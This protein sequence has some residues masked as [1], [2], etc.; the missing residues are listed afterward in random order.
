[1]LSYLYMLIREKVSL[2]H[3]TTFRMGPSTSY[4]IEIKTTSDLKEACSF[5]KNKN[6]PILVIGGG[7]NV[8]FKDEKELDAVVLNIKIKGL[9]ILEDTS[10]YSLIE[11]GAGE[12][13]DEVVDFSVRQGLTGIECLSYIPGTAG[14]TPVQNVGA[15]GQEISDTLVHLTAYEVSSGNMRTFTKEE[16]GFGYRNSVFKQESK[17]KYV[18]TSIV[19]KLSK[20]KPS[21][22]SYPGVESYF[23]KH[24]IN[25]P[26]LE[27]I[28]Q[29]II[30]IRKNKLPDPKNIASVGSFFKNPII[31]K[32]KSTDLQSKY[33]NIP[34]FSVDATHDKIAAGW[35]ID[36]LGLKGKEFGNLMIYEN[37]ALV[38]VN[39][40]NATYTELTDLVKTIKNSVF[41]VYGIELEQEPIILD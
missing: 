7:S 17:D 10:E 29:A 6:L 23:R 20:N 9:K 27:Q 30:E 26:T 16:C 12:I 31:L 15:Y 14:A 33:K 39:K 19:L 35:L 24:S 8:L 25:R 21:I 37:N 32:S 36:S 18:I 11:I 2:K 1:M 3:H 5:A 34:V 13:W 22:P 28:R 41:Q 4:F 40:G 38:I